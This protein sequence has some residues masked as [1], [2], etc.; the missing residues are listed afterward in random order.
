MVETINVRGGGEDII[1]LTKANNI[2][3]EDY[4]YL[5]MEKAPGCTSQEDWEGLLPWNIPM[6]EAR[7]LRDFLLSAKPDPERTEPYILRG[8]SI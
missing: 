7:A 6:E 8:K 4:L 5:V 1:L 2:N 3:P